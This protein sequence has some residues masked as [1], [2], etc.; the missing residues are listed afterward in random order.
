MKTCSCCKQLQPFS[1]FQ[2]RKL[3]KDGLTASCKSCLKIRDKNRE[4]DQRREK[5]RLYQKTENGKIAHKKAMQNYNHNYPLKY[6]A[7]IIT[8]NYIRDKK[9]K[10]EYVCSVC[11]SDKKIEAHHDDYTKP[12]EVRWLC[13]CCHKEWH[14]TNKPIF[15]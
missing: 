1:N 13:E 9:L 4:N 3:S 2:Q 5:R 6:A 10:Q 11:N 14:R 8:R 7:H 15:N 12:L